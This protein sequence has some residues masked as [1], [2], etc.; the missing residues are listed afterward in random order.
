MVF[1]IHY[2]NFIVCSHCSHFYDDYH[3]W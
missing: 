1:P 3:R 2:C